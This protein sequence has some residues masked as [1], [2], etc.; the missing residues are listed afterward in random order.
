MKRM[1]VE[2]EEIK[3]EQESGGGKGRERRWK[4]GDG[5]EIG[6]KRGKCVVGR[7][8]EQKPK[9]MEQKR[10]SWKTKTMEVK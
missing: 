6:R 9:S 1:E 10:K 8:S 5:I 3:G 2:E 4:S 7:G